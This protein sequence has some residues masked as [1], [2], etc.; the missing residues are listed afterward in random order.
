MSANGYS[1]RVTS[2]SGGSFYGSGRSIDMRRRSASLLGIDDKLLR[3]P[4]GL[5]KARPKVLELLLDEDY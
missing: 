3:M 2:P 4:N 1:P 5:H